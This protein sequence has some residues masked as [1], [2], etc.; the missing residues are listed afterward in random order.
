MYNNNIKLLIV[1]PM[2][3]PYVRE[4][5]GSLESMQAIVRGA[6]EATYPFE[7]L[8]ALVYNAD[9]MNLQP[10]RI[11]KDDHGVPYDIVCG[12]FFLAGI[13][14][15]RFVSLTDEQIKKYQKLYSREMVFTIPNHTK[16]EK[17]HHER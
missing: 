5:D 6:I 2:K 10:N 11:L 8:V 9:G 15:E 13:G 7:D 16:K 1:E 3:E 12:T 4:S 17:H 14:G